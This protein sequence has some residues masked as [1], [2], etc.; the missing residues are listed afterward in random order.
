MPLAHTPRKQISSEA[1][2]PV[3]KEKAG[4]S[5]KSTTPTANVR[6]SIGEWES[7]RVRDPNVASSTTY[8]VSPKK[9][10][11]TST[12]PSRVAPKV[13]LPQTGKDIKR[14]SSVEASGGSQKPIVSTDRV[15]EGRTWLQRAKTQ[16]GESRNLKSEIKAGITLAVE[17]MYKLIKD[18]A[19]EIEGLKHKPGQLEDKMIQRDVTGESTVKATEKDTVH[20]TTLIEMHSKLLEEN[21]RRLEALQTT[22]EQQ[23][24]DTGTPS[25]ARVAAT[26]GTYGAFEKRNTLHSVVVTSKDETESGEEVLEKASPGTVGFGHTVPEKTTDN[27]ILGAILVWQPDFWGGFSQEPFGLESSCLGSLERAQR[28]LSG[29]G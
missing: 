25:Y 1:N 14:R 24:V 20:L 8:T 12:A 10:A 15:S 16:L 6:R 23:K 22:L 7:S 9:Q 18:A 26:R 5:P 21:S 27:Q 2:S 19:I 17:A 28:D 11:Q 4:P 3:D 29:R 13:T